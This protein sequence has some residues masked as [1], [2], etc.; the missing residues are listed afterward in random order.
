MRLLALLVVGA[1]DDETLVDEYREAL[2]GD[3]FDMA[4]AAV[5]R[6]DDTWLHVDDE[7]AAAGF[8]EA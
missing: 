6:F 3:V 8:R 7:H 2:G 5:Q 4:R 1:R